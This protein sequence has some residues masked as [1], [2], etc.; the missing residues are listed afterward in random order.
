MQKVGAAAESEGKE[1]PQASSLADTDDP[2]NN[3][4]ASNVDKETQELIDEMIAEEEQ[5]RL[6]AEQEAEEELA[7]QQQELR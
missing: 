2:S 5:A 3:T 4:K 6:E 7:R 1:T